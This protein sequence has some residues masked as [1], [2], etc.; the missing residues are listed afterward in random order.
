MPMR[1]AAVYA[2]LDR[3][4]RLML[5]LLG[6]LQATPPPLA[7][8]RVRAEFG[9]RGL[10]ALTDVAQHAV[11]RLIRDGF[12]L[13]IGG[14]RYH[15][16]GLPA[17]TAT[18]SRATATFRWTAGP[19]RVDVVY[20]LRAGWGFVS[21]QLCVTGGGAGGYHV[22]D[23]TLLD[24]ELVDTIRDAYVPGSHHASLGTGDYGGALRFAGNRGLLAVVPNPFLQ[25]RRDGNAFAIRYQPGMDWR[26]GKGPLPSDPG[27]PAPG[28]GRTG[29][30][31][32][33]PP[34]PCK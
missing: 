1:T 30:H 24:A 5:V 33:G 17:P 26:A 21:K 12:S 2:A 15:S 19:Y 27:P 29:E 25:F 14:T 7:N 10:V 4:D 32:A 8:A 16:Q 11:Y 34:S 31:T 28:R 23:V 9:P 6:L 3:F 18:A 20:E 22:D 13:S